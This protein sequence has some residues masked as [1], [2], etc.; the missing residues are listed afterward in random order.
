MFFFEI[1]LQV[2]VFLLTLYFLNRNKE[3]EE[4]AAQLRFEEAKKHTKFVTVEQVEQSG[5]TY[6]LVH[7][8]EEKEFVAQGFTEEEALNNTKAMFPDMNI[9]SVID[10]K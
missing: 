6:F 8:F 9:F 7:T 4:Q 1:I 3:S 2:F 10:N 5:K